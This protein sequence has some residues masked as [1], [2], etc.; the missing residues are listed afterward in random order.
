VIWFKEQK[1]DKNIQKEITLVKKKLKKLNRKMRDL[2][3]VGTGWGQI[4]VLQ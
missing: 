1:T 3:K 2:V 4:E